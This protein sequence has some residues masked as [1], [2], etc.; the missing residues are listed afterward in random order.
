MRVNTAPRR[1]VDKPMHKFRV[2]EKVTWQS[3]PVSQAR[4]R[5]TVTIVLQLPPL[6]DNLQYRIKN[7]KDPHE[8]V[9][10]EHELSRDTSPSSLSSETFA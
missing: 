7:L 9:V 3:Q 5:G 6:G 1:A 4:S 10:L 8:F 2:G